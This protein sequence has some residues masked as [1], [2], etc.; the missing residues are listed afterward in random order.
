MGKKKKERAAQNA[1]RK[2]ARTE[3]GVNK[4]ANK[5]ANNEAEGENIDTEKKVKVNS[6]Q[7]SE[8]ILDKK[9]I[10][11]ICFGVIIL[12]SLG[13]RL[14]LINFPLWYD[15]GCSIAT[16]VNSF[17]V[18]INDYLWNHDLQHTPFYFYILH[19]IM[20]IFGDGVVILRISS[21][22]VSMALLPVTYI[23]TEKLASKK[24]ALFAMLL[25]GVNTFQV[26][27]SIEIRM[28]P[29]VILLALLSFNYLIDYDRKEDTASLIKLGIVNLLN[30]YFLTGSIIFVVVQFI[31]YTCYLDWKNADSKKISRYVISNIFVLLGFIPYFI[32]IGH[33]GAVR[34]KFLVTDISAF[35]ATNFWGMFQNLVSC[36]PGHIHETRFE[37]FFNY[38]KGDTPE[39]LH[40]NSVMEMKVWTLIILPIIT[41]FVGFIN[42]LRDKEKLN[43]VILATITVTFGIFTFLSYTKLIAFTGRYLIFITPFIF[44][45][46]AVGLSKLNKYLALTIA[47]LYSI[48]CIAAFHMTFDWYKNIAEFSL[49]SPAD[50]A[51][52]HLPGKKNLVIMPFASS[53]SFYYFKDDNMPTVMPLELFHKVRDPENTDI[54]DPEQIEGFKKGDKYEIFQKAITSNKP[55]SMNLMRYLYS[56]ISKVPKGGYILWVV[57]YSDNYAIRPPE[58][59]KRYYSNI[60]NV[61]AYTMTGTLSKFD[62]DL[63]ALLLSQCKFIRR[64]HDL[65]N[66]FFLFQKK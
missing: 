26:L 58:Q 6:E 13:L 17:P 30:P 62:I 63:I 12:I 42:S 32:L 4:G 48:G 59:V 51:R 35:S 11:W 33:Y 41:M 10:F 9:N 45:L 39:I 24:V 43:H 56:Y 25:M 14:T 22:I 50:Y 18:G 44:I 5:G 21:L 19:Y 38:I 49:K 15:E 57:Y 46:M 31:I 65:S 7:K 47:I 8:D 37:P 66:S 1:I 27:Y 36:D 2:A 29:Y 61:K 52:K 23:V 60:D 53:V 55:F 34:S 20:Q 16:A 3:A 54:Y 40:K 64:D 28:Y